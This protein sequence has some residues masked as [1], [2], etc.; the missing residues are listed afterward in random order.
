MGPPLISGGNY[1]RDE[2]TGSDR[3]SMGPP[4]ISGGNAD[5]QQQTLNT[6]ACFNGA[7]ADQ[8]RKLILCHH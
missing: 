3:A 1:G 4:L 7:A 8:R 2:N 6:S 5:D